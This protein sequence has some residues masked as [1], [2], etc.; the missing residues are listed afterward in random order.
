MNK[1]EI[2]EL[3]SRVHALKKSSENSLPENSYFLDTDTVLCYPCRHG[4]SRYPYYNDGLVLFA[5]SGGYIDCV[6]SIFNIFKPAHYNEDASVA[7]FAG[8][9]RGEQYFPVSVTGAA[10][11]L[12]EEG[13]ERY[14]VYTPVCAYY[15]AETE[16]A[17]FALRVYVDEN[18]HLRFSVGAVNLAEEREIYLCSYFEPMLRYREVDDFFARMTK[19]AEHFGCGSYLLKADNDVTDYFAVNNAVTGNAVKKYS[20]TAKNTFIGRVGG[21]ITNAEALKNGCPE[22]ETAKTNTTDLNVV[23]DMVHFSLEQGGF[24]ALDYE[25]KVTVDKAAA[26]EFIGKPIDI[27]GAD[28]S[29][30]NGAEREKEIFARTDI[31]FNEWHN[32]K[33]HTNVINSFIKNVQRQISFCALGKN[34]AG[35]NLGIRDVF[36][37][38]ETALIWQ[39]KEARNQIVRVMN[40]ILEDGRAPRQISFPAVET[41]V[42][43]LDLRP[44]IDQGFWIISALHTYLSYTDDFSILDEVCG[45][46]RVEKTFGPVMFSEQKDSI[47][48]HL[49]RITEFLLSNL[50]EKTH[51]IHA[52]YGDWNDALDGMGRTDDPDKE[53]GDGV[54][55]MA[56]LQ[57]YLALGQMCDVIAHTSKDTALIAKYN[58][59][60]AL[61]AKGVAENALH[62]DENGTARMVHGWGE[63]QSYYVGSYKDYDG[64]SRR[65]LTANSF[66]AISGMIENFPQYKA[67]IAD[68][69]FALDT[70][71]GP[72]TFDK[73]FLEVAKEVGRIST[74]TPGTY[75]NACAY[76]HA[77]TFGAQ[78]LFLMGYH[79]QAWEMLEKLMV[80]SHEN[81]T[82]TTFVMPNSY[83][84]D[85][86][87]GFNGE[88]MGD[89]YTG[90]GTVLIKDIIKLG[91]GIEPT[92]SSLKIAPAGY[93][94]AK[95]A[96]V[97]L[98]VKGCRITVKYENNNSPERKIFLG[99]TELELKEDALRNIKLAEIPKGMLYNGAVITIKD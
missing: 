62:K 10:R 34:Y 12:F 56:T 98:T 48:C 30:K 54:S 67:D 32:K 70:R 94:P 20:T 99:E 4:Q 36:Q 80:I 74:I 77:G 79:K 9:K 58:D 95:E 6:D 8:E 2:L 31:K 3:I 16:R 49:I 93:F 57:M 33:L 64:F 18:R 83:C 66:T 96:Q 24:A 44:F 52:L 43:E 72:R 59:Y 76:V 28:N 75:E 19:Y 17:V 90:S 40:F 39:G 26:E 37:Q 13:V 61:I 47:L 82:R 68:N 86:E 41:M 53:Y 85:E 15:I 45:Y 91:F 14:T 87:Y 38:L 27:S 92:L 60:R 29:L 89:W 78:A 81:V 25:I 21:N 42:P 5:H 84:D 63:G 97:S 71:F 7:F 55:I 50:D 11:Q 73:P 65:S 1:N 22:R 69:I 88:S 23:C 46:Y 35:P 51:C